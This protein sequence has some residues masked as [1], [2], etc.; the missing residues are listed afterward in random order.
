MNI[1]APKRMTVDE[2]LAWATGQPGRYELIDG[3][4]REMSPE[5]VGHVEGKI[6]AYMALK[7]A[8]KRAEVACFVLSDGA[9]VRISKDTAFEP[10]ALVYPGPRANADSLEIP[11]PLIV[12]EVGSPSTHKYDAGFKLNGYMSLPSLQH[13]LLVNAATKVVVHLKKRGAGPEFESTTL[14]S[15][16]LR[17]DPPGLEIPAEDFFAID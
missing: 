3:V 7:S 2:Y 4:V 12:V 9:T 16:M 10:D 6:T 11:N 17:L 14:T 13:V 1:H 8:I 15:G 5:K